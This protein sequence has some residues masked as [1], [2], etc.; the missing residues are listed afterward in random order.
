MTLFVFDGA[1]PSYGEENPNEFVIPSETALAV[2]R[3]FFR[4]RQ[5]SP[6]VSWFEL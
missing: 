6:D 2:A 4:T 5:M 1:D 3:E